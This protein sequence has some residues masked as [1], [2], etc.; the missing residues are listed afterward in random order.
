MV[1]FWVQISNVPLMC[2]TRDIGLF[3]GKQIGVVCDIDVGASGIVWVNTFEL[4]LEVDVNKPLKR[5]VRVKLGEPPSVVMMLLR[6]EKLLEYCF[7]CGLIGHSVRECVSVSYDPVKEGGDK[8]RFGAWLR[9]SSPSKSGGQRQNREHVEDSQQ[10]R[11][12]GRREDVRD[13]G[14]GL[15]AGLHGTVLHG[16]DTATIGKGL[17]RQV[18]LRPM[19]L[20][21]VRR[22]DLLHMG[23]KTRQLLR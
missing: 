15:V 18:L 20:C 8:A 9:A 16:K 21:M 1:E 14:T 12:E 11:R 2:M 3:L 4:G 23:W 5:Y 6:Y 17:D 10:R 13:S 22:L 19:V 7:W